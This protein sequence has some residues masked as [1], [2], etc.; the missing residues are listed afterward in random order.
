VIARR[1]GD[2]LGNVGAIVL[3]CILLGGIGNMLD[4]GRR[5]IESEP[6]YAS[7]GY[8]PPPA[9]DEVAQA[10][11]DSKAADQRVCTELHGPNAVALQLPDG[12]HRCTDKHGRKLAR[13]AVS[14]PSHRFAQ[15][16]P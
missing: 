8:M 12:S 3:V 5:A 14:I 1:V 10:I 7:Y 16:A 15:V 9:V 2:T 6:T 11:A 4:A 13:S